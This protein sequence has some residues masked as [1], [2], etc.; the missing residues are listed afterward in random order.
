MANYSLQQIA[1]AYNVAKNVYD[2]NMTS[3]DGIKELVEKNE[4]NEG[5]AQMII[6][7]IFPGMMTGSEF[8]RTLGVSF[9]EYFLAGILKDYST[10]EFSNAL[11]S[12]KKH[13]DYISKY[14]DSKVKL[15]T[16]YDK[17]FL[18][19][20]SPSEERE[21]IED[22][23]DK[24]EQDEIIRFIKSSGKTKA[25]VIRELNN[26]K[27]TDPEV[28]MINH[29]AYKRDNKVIAQIKFVRDFK[30]QIC[31]TTIKK[32]DGSNYI[33]AAH[34]KPKHKGG[35]ECLENIILLCPNHH[36]EFDYGT[37]EINIHTKT[38]L[39]F[40]LNDISYEIRLTID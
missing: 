22:K 2:Q 17:Y 6:V 15:K 21:P 39:K 7:Q 24:R 25:E 33:E 29:K 36:K 10:L 34:I 14:K 26:T 35:R 16:V 40:M 30:C 27:E 20:S 13:I 38:H 8:T 11:L 28:I 31:G 37:L 1:Y 4:M 9:F 19:L 18:I 5:S 3:K 23:E 12:I 32:R